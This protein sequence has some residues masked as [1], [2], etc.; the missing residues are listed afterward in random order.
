MDGSFSRVDGSRDPGALVR[1]LDEA[2]ELAP[3]R[4][5][6]RRLLAEL[7]LRPG[8]RVLD[9]GCGTG[10][11]AVAIADAARVTGLDASATMIAEAR[12]RAAGRGV[13]ADFLV[14]TA[15][16][17]GLAGGSF[18]ACRF[19]RVLQH[20]DDPLAALREA[21]RVLRP[22]GRVAAFEPDWTS[23]EVAGGDPAVAAGALDARLRSIASPAV[24]ARLPGLLAAAGFAGVRS[25]TLPLA[26]EGPAA[27]RGL[28][29]DAY[30]RAAVTT[31]TVTAGAAAR[32]LAA[33]ER[34]EL[35]A[36]A[37]M[38]LASAT[39]PGVT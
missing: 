38:H 31:G 9:V 23:L 10:E 7:R 36:R 15:E 35:R 20:L 4:E 34:G 16:R 24:G 22:G 21:A 6:D 8:H 5:A 25:W 29:L 26:G 39:R 33:A 1:Y 2:G 12:R 19:E 14:G 37:T 27:L 11:D 18:D 32:W 30:A 17:L 13:A 28:R 3:F